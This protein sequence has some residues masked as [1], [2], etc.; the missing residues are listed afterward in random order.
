MLALE[1]VPRTEIV[2]LASPSFYYAYFDRH[3]DPLPQ[4]IGSFQIFVRGYKD[5]SLCI[6]DLQLNPL[7]DDQ[8]AQFRRYFERLVVLD[9][10]IRNTDR[11]NDNWMIK[12]VGS[13][14]SE[15][16][17]PTTASSSQAAPQP[18]PFLKI[19]AIDNGLAFPFKHPDSWRAY[20]FGWTSLPPAQVPFSDETKELFLPKLID[21]DWC[22]TLVKELRMIAQADQ[23]FNEKQFTKQM[24][25]MRGQVY[26]PPFFTLPLR[27]NPTPI[28]STQIFNLAEA[29]MRQY[30]PAD[31]VEM[32]PLTISHVEA[33]TG[34]MRKFMSFRMAE[35]FFTYC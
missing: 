27:T 11:G 6:P 8:K 9:Y 19:A 32:T 17:S 12:I 3:S 14:M 20:P 16:P 24:A 34:F 10:I 28:L 13:E 31:L 23:D 33:S 5:A 35:P 30:T 22:D 4:K 26:T 29:L 2:S 25:V 1:V 15:P 18:P 21:P 7:S